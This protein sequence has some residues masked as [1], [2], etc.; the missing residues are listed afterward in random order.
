MFFRFIHRS[1]HF[2]FIALF[3]L[4]Q[5]GFG[6]VSNYAFTETTGTYQTIHINGGGTSADGKG[7]ST[8]LNDETNYNSD[9]RLDDAI[10][11]PFEFCI[12]GTTYPIGT[13]ISMYHNGFIVFASS[14]VATYASGGRHRPLSYWNNCISA[15]GA[16][17][18]TGSIVV[19]YGVRIEGVSGNRVIIFQWGSNVLDRWWRRANLYGGHANDRLHFQIRLYETTNVIEFHYLVTDHPSNNSG[20]TLRQNIQVGIRGANASDY[21]VIRLTGSNS[22]NRPWLNNTELAPGL[23]NGNEI[24]TNNMHFNNIRNN[25][26]NKPGGGTIS[27]VGTQTPIV[28]G[29]G[30][31]AVIFRWTP[32]GGPEA[33]PSIHSGCYFS[34]LPVELTEFKVVPAQTV[35][36]INWTTASEVNSDY[37]HVERSVNGGEWNLVGRV[38]SAGNSSTTLHYELEDYAFEPVVNYYRLK[39]VDLDGTTKYYNIVSV[40]NRTSKSELIKTVNT[41]GQEVTNYYKGLVIEI[42]SDGSTQKYYRH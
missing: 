13:S 34:P 41:M 15:F 25:A 6:Q 30:N 7:T 19:P 28:L 24:N 33:D 29:T 1:F 36:Q 26:N 22:P 35:N 18:T 12:G 17:L 23:P 42:Y 32:V 31:N 11:L 3:T 4:P 10:R 14:I 21:S 20:G 40:D 5:V 39:Q 9:S 2:L 37:F 16:P 38:Q 8:S 27:T